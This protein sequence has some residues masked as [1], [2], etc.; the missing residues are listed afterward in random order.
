[1]MIGVVT[2]L[3]ERTHRL[4]RPVSAV[5]D[6]E[7]VLDEHMLWLTRWISRRYLCSWGQAIWAALP[8]GMKR[9]ATQTVFLSGDGIDAPGLAADEEKLLSLLASKG[10][11]ALSYILAICGPGGRKSLAALEKRGLVIVEDRW[12]GGR[13]RPLLRKYL[14]REEGKDASGL[15]PA[16]AR[17]WERLKGS[18]GIPSGEVGSSSTAS[19]LVSHGLARWEDREAGILSRPDLPIEEAG[20]V[21]LTGEQNEAFQ[22]IASR[23]VGHGFGA[24]LLFGVTASGKTEVYIR[25]VGKAVEQGR[26]ALVLVPEIGLVSQMATRLSRRFRRVGVW[27]SELSDGERYDVW[28]QSRRGKLEIVV[29]VRSAVFAPLP[30]LGLVVVDEEHDASYQ[31]RDQEPH[32]HAREAALARAEKLGIQIILGS[33]TPSAESYHLARVGAYRLHIMA[34][35]VGGAETPRLQLVD[36]RGQQGREDLLSP[37]LAGELKRTVSLGEQAMLLLNRR[38]FARSVQCRRCGWMLRCKN[39]DISLAYHRQ[40]DR[41]LCHYCGF[42]M[43]LPEACPACGSGELMPRG[44][45]IQRLEVELERLLPSVRMLRMDSDTTGR[46]GSHEKILARFSSGGA[47]VL[48]GTQ[49][50]SKGHHFP[51]VTLVGILDIDDLLGLPDFRCAERASQLLFQ[52]AGR[53]GRGL[54]PGLV[55]VQTRLPGSD[56]LGGLGAEGY[57]RLLESE[58]EQRK[59]AG[60]PPYTKIVLVTVSSGSR[61]QAEE[62][63]EG[64][65][66]RLRGTYSELEVLGPAPAPILRL[67]GRFRFQILLKH[68]RLEPL[69]EAAGSVGRGQGGVSVKLEVE[70]VSTL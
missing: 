45:G 37:A 63:A 69:L 41:A 32:Y 12:R 58:L 25:A 22:D 29:G 24:H 64:I 55:M 66:R 52:M 67:R 4:C 5:L 65:A 21:Q 13:E 3:R 44:G 38:G 43:R 54:L 15:T 28:D 11:L 6:E 19:W 36:C 62:A 70:P 31:Q 61:E 16:R 35:R 57:R 59:A 27:H 30:S 34:T 46:K 39:C 42:R 20:E 51:G 23:M 60:Y 49:M 68:P 33:A 26:Q 18:E 14:V 2:E 47:K 9:R 10:P 7:P 1:M 40:E 50:I 56:A 53:A 8:P 17:L 48:I